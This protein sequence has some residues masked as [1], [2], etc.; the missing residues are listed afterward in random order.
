MT[1]G[2][3]LIT[4]AIDTLASGQDLGLEDAAAV[5]HEIMAGNASEIQIAA[6]LIALRTKGET[7]EELAGLARTMRAMAARVAVASDDLLDT[8]GTGGGR[9]TFNVSTTAA[10]IAA[11]A[12]CTVAKHGNRSATGLSGSADVL[13]ALGARI[14]LDPD[15]VARCIDE[16]G[17]GF[18]FAPAHHQATRYVIPVRRELAVRTI[19]NFLG[20]LTNPAG[21]TRQLIGVSDPAYLET[22]AGALAL[23]GTKHALLVASEDGLDELSISAPTRVVEVIGGELRRYDLAPE[24]VGLERAPAE[25][26]PGGDPGQN[27]GDR[28]GHLLR[29][30]GRAARP[31]GAQCGRRDLRRRWRG[32]ARAGRARGRA[33]DRRRRGGRGARPLR[34]TNQRPGQAAESRVNRLDPIIAGTREV[35]AERRRRAPLPELDLA[36]PS[37]PPPA[38]SA[39]S[40]MRIARPGLSLIA[41]HKRRSPS[42]GPIRGDLALE[43]VVS[44]YERG[45]AAALSILTEGPNFGGSLDDLRAARRASALPLLRKDFVVDP[46]QVHEASAAGADAILLIVA[47]LSAPELSALHS[48]AI[49]LGLIALV[50]VHDER[51]LDTALSMDPVPPAIIGINNR[52]LKTLRTDTRTTFDLLERIQIPALTVAESGFS[53]PEQLDELEAAGVDGVLIGEALMRSIDVEAATRALDRSLSRRVRTMVRMTKIKFCGI[54]ELD[55]AERAVAAGAWAVGRDLLAAVAAPLRPGRGGRDRGRGQAAR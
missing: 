42:A 24:D 34:T 33:G 17:F 22:M 23:L 14:D 12:G 35:V 46:Y 30:A 45:G 3:D 1:A 51:E 27:A 21:A 48:E 5:L 20:P 26:I 8:A 28:A 9:R 37:G 39:R 7:V 41:E 13:E 50:E 31:G 54:T 44:A 15:Q 38:T 2:P 40:G 18:M 49:G 36:W 19:F 29:S 4:R 10:L 11:G 47:A 25:E 16:V 55:D 53:R 52:D 6:F 32:H 43:D